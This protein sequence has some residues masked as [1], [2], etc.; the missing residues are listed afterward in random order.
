M[1]AVAR[2]LFAGAAVQTT[3]ASSISGS[4]TTIN[5]VANTGWPSG[6]E[7]FFVVIDPDQANE[8]KV[9]VTRS[10][11]TLTAASTGKRGVDGTAA[12][13]HAAGAVVYPCV[14]AT[15]L[16]EAN[17]FVSTLTT[18]GDLLVQGASAV[19]RLGVGTNGHTLVADSVET[20][21]VK[22]AALPDID[23]LKLVS[24]NEET[25]SYTLVLADAFGIVE[26]N[27]ATANTLTVPPDADTPFPIGTQIVVLQTGAGQTTITAGSGVTVNSAAGYLKL[28]VQWAGATLVKR[29]TNL[30]VAV[31][32]LAP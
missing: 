3:L 15:D 21:G 31:G 2:R 6:A 11:T 17:G 27:V 28:S 18:K 23:N 14:T 8:E 19:G 12:S 5:I 9:L 24:F 7:E 26:M 22:W 25:A 20:L 30:W 13:S 4:D 10:G 29:S 16:D 1:M 32:D